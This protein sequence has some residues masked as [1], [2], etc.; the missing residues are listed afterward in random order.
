MKPPDNKWLTVLAFLF[1]LVTFFGIM[2]LL[3]YFPSIPN[4]G[5]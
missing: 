2:W 1:A 5:P 4:W 3:G